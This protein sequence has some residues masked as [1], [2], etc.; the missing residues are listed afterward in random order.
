MR[1]GNDHLPA[2]QSRVNSELFPVH[3]K[4]LSGDS[5]LLCN[6]G[7][8]TVDGKNNPHDKFLLPWQ[9]MG[10]AEYCF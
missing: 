5:I 4:A 9:Q 1:E 3:D 7:C 8:A 6:N 2:N 10:Y